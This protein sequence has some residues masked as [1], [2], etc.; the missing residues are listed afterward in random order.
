MVDLGKTKYWGKRKKTSYNPDT[1]RQY[2]PEPDR[3][4]LSES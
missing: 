1:F 2:H 3:P 4:A